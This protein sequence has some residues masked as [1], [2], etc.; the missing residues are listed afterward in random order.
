MLIDSNR[1]ISR[2][3]H[4]GRNK[5]FDQNHIT[6]IVSSMTSS[7]ATF[8][9][10]CAHVGYSITYRVIKHLAARIDTNYFRNTLICVLPASILNK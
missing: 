6:L 1:Q 4:D 2:E 8:C 10:P 7:H 5:S 9:D 3:P